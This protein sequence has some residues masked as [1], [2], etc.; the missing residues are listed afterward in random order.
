LIEYETYK[1]KIKIS[2][3]LF[4]NRINTLDFYKLISYSY[5]RE[6]ICHPLFIKKKR[7]TIIVHLNQDIEIL[8]SNF[9]T[10]TRNEVRRAFKENIEFDVENNRQSFLSFYN[11]FALKKGQDLISKNSFMRLKNLVITKASKNNE[12]LV[13][14][15]YLLHSGDSKVRLINSASCRLEKNANKSLIGWANRFLHY[16]DMIYFKDRN[17]IQYDLGG[18]AHHTRKKDKHKIEAFKCEFGGKIVEEYFY[19]SIPHYVGLKLYSTLNKNFI[20]QRN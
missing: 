1:G 8:F 17:I 2:H 19:E 10:K 16:R 11:A 6:N 5:V 4:A 18:T 12:T 7:F 20:Q 9:K 14:H 15:A 13:M 3:K